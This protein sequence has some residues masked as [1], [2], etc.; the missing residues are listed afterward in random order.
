MTLELPFVSA[1]SVTAR[2][3]HP[4]PPRRGAARRGPSGQRVEA[5][6]MP[7]DELPRRGRASAT[8]ANRLR[9]GARGYGSDVRRIAIV[10]SRAR[11]CSNR[12]TQ[13]GRAGRAGRRPGPC[14]GEGVSCRHR[15]RRLCRSEFLN[16]VVGTVMGAFDG[17]LLAAAHHSHLEADGAFALYESWFASCRRSRGGACLASAGRSQPTG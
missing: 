17:S 10:A 16:G 8:S 7:N 12:R 3:F 9:P 15:C 11:W 5:V 13:R 14:R 1:W 4:P 2:M 6:W